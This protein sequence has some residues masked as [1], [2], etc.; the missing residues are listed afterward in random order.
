MSMKY[1]DYSSLPMNAMK[2]VPEENENAEK[3]V[4]LVKESGKVTGYQLESGKIVSKEEGVAMAKQGGIHGVG[5]TEN[6]GTEYLKSLPDGSE[7]NNLG[8][9]PSIS[10]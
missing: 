4:S 2:E 5:I 3:I 10:K 7:D 8:N 6:Q 9:L 1:T